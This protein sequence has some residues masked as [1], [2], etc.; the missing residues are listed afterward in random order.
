[1]DDTTEGKLSGNGIANY[2]KSGDALLP[3]SESRLPHQVEHLSVKVDIPAFMGDSERERYSRV[4]FR[5]LVSPGLYPVCAPAVTKRVTIITE[6]KCL[7]E[8][9]THNMYVCIIQLIMNH[10]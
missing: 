10:F 6:Q 8:T 7:R 2:S 1:M 5:H 3:R 4:R 9:G